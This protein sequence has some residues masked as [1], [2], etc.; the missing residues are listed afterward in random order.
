VIIAPRFKRPGREVRVVAHIGGKILGAVPF[1]KPA[2]GIGAVHSDA[3]FG[4]RRLLACV[5]VI[6]LHAIDDPS[7]N[8]FAKKVGAACQLV[9]DD[10]GQVGD[11]ADHGTFPT[12]QLIDRSALAAR[13][14]LDRSAGLCRHPWSRRSSC[15]R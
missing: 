3:E 13:V 12:V 8:H 4:P 5:A 2:A 10:A 14:H 11:L 9:P 15:V 6:A 1:V 7:G